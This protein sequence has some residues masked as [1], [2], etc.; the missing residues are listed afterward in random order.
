[1]FSIVF[2]EKFV[3]WLYWG[4]RVTCTGLLTHHLL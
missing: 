3:Y 4:L 2:V 1:L